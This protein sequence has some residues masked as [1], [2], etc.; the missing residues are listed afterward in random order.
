MRSD[1]AT[2]LD[3]F[4]TL[5]ERHKSKP[6]TY[7]CFGA[8]VN[9]LLETMTDA[10]KT[11]KTRSDVAIAGLEARVAQLELQPPSPHYEGIC[12]QGKMYARG[13][14]T[15][16]AGGLWLALQTTTQVPGGSDQ[17]KLIVKSGEAL[18]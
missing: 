12:E 1:P 4:D 15:T 10:I 6:V 14:L 2:S 11:V 8:A 5:I 18:R 16:K 17:W 9:V 13:S 7:D 3:D